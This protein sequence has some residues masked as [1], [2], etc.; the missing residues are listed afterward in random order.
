MLFLQVIQRQVNHVTIL[1]NAQLHPTPVER[2]HRSVETQTVRSFVSAR[3]DTV[4][5]V[6]RTLTN[7]HPMR[8]CE[9][10]PTLPIARTHREDFLVLAS[11]VIVEMEKAALILM[12][13]LVI[14]LAI[15]WQIVRIC[16]VLSDAH[17]PVVSVEMGSTTVLILMSACCQLEDAKATLHATTRLV[18]ST[19]YA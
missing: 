1:M 10:A 4:V 2:A 3:R 8:P 13:V 14:R 15:N 5:L 9:L 18:V 6:A 7:A 16:L 11:V 19:A 17:A 12:S